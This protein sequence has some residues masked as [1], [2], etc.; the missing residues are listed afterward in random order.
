M[1]IAIVR[2]AGCVA[3]ADA[4]GGAECVVVEAGKLA[5][6]AK[7]FKKFSLLTQLHTA[8][9]SMRSSTLLV[10]AVAVM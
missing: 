1:K 7:S 2:G 10:L 3:T 6:F 5:N 4:R 9:Q 8:V